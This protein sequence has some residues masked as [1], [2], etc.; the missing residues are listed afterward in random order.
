[1]NPRGRTTRSGFNFRINRRALVY[2]GVSAVALAGAAVG[3]ALSDG[4]VTLVVLG[5]AG[6]YVGALLAARVLL[7]PG[8][9]G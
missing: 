3:A 1:M 5:G 2:I 6:A 7:G 4:D 9:A 8:A